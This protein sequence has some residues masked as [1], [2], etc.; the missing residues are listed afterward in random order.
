VDPDVRRRG[1]GTAL[2]TFACT[3]LR[4]LGV[5]RLFLEVAERNKEAQLFYATYGF[6]LVGYRPDYYPP[7]HQDNALVMVFDL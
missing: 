2:V 6:R 1:L 7:P 5:A 3:V 4:C